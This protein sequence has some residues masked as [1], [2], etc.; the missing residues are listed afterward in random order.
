MLAASDKR[1]EPGQVGHELERQRCTVRGTHLCRVVA[2][3]VAG[4][5]AVEPELVRIRSGASRI[6]PTSPASEFFANSPISVDMK[7]GV[8]EGGREERLPQ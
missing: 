1:G 7:P 2:P 4:S 8:Q 3:R 5:S 6:G